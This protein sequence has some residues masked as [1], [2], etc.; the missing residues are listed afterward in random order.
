MALRAR[1][2]SLAAGWSC[3]CVQQ[4]C[5]GFAC[6]HRQEQLAAG[7]QTSVCRHNYND[8]RGGADATG[9]VSLS[10]LESQARVEQIGPNHPETSAFCTPCAGILAVRYRYLLSWRVDPI[11]CRLPNDCNR[12]LLFHRIEGL[13]DSPAT[14]SLMLH[15]AEDPLRSLV[16]IIITLRTHVHN[17][18][19]PARH[20]CSW[21]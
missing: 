19:D 2:L 12:L 6:A 8:R 11:H 5:T 14:R 10:W 9:S 3:L 7:R 21:L 18:T 16:I 13:R 4:T 20:T 17:M 15:N 1:P